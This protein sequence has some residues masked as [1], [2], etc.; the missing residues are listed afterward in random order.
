MAASLAVRTT[1]TVRRA[2][3]VL[4]S[5]FLIFV[6]AL[7]SLGAAAY[8]YGKS[9]TQPR[10]ARLQAEDGLLLQPKHE[11]R[12]RQVRGDEPVREG[13]SIKTQ[14][15]MQA[16]VSFFDGV[17]LT[18]AEETLVQ[19][20]ELRSSRFV[21]SEQRLRLVQSQGWSRLTILPT[22]DHDVGRY[23]IQLDSLQ[24]EAEGRPGT[25]LDLG[26][27]LRPAVWRPGDTATTGPFEARVSVYAGAASARAA[28]DEVQ[29]VAGQTTTAVRGSRP[30]PPAGLRRN[31]V[32]NGDFFDQ[33]P[34]E[35]A[36]LRQWHITRDQGR[37]G[38]NKHG[39]VRL[40]VRELD[41]RPVPV[42]RLW[43][44]LN[45][46]DNAVVGIQQ[47][48]NLPLSHLS[49]LR[50]RFDLQVIYHSLSGGGWANSEYPVI[51]KITYRDRKNRP[52][53]WYRGFFTHNEERRPTPNGTKVPQGEWVTFEQDLLRLTDLDGKLVDP[54]PV[55]L[56]TLD[57]Y[58]GGHDFEALISN[59]SIEGE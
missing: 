11:T 6:V 48:L 18:L 52:A 40:D 21:T 24:I 30:T 44:R 47:P 1:H 37:D 20:A 8:I 54:E 50:L 55:V 3:L 5:S 12:F 25:L 49:S 23:T 42:V 15:G 38:G 31:Y 27:E 58:A 36:W 10:E 4:F 51:V 41:G 39:E 33:A 35:P 22:T 13:D 9:A 56:E 28:G 45:T 59:V 43:R 34:L 57:I 53:N 14:S 19:V 2:W 17:I 26:F 32:R 7:T 16:R 46:D 29:L